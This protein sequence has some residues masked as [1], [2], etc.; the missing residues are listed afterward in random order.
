MNRKKSTRNTV[1]FLTQAGVIAAMYTALTYVSAAAGLAFNAVQ[2]R[3]SEVM[4]VLALYTPAAIPGLTIGCIISNLSSAL[5]WI[6]IIAGSL[7]TLLAS[8]CIYFTPKLKIKNFPISVPLFC[9]LFNSVIVGLEIWYIDPSRTAQLFFISALE[10]AAGEITVCTIGAL[11]L[12][13][14]VKR[15]KIFEKNHFNI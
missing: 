9:S 14:I 3:L 13:P 12:P 1:L 11:I 7:A 2:F 6:D 4:C 10:V 15:A 8:V 5:G